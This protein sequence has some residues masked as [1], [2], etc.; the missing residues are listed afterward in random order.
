[1]SKEFTSDYLDKLYDKLEK[2]VKQLEQE[3]KQLKEEIQKIK[4]DRVDLINTNRKDKQ[5]LEKIKELVNNGFF[6]EVIYDGQGNF[7]QNDEDKTNKLKEILDS[8]EKE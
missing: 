4:Y 6:N 3:N 7:D 1:M 2:G 5:K 8:Q